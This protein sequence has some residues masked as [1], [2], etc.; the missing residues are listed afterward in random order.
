MIMVGEEGGVLGEILDRLASLLEHEAET[1]SRVKAAVRYPIIVIVAIVIAFTVLVTLVIPKFAAL[2]AQFKAQLPLPTRILIGINNVIKNYWYLILVSIFGAYYAFRVYISTKGGRKVW[3][4]VKIRV[5]IIG[6]LILKVIM[7][8]FSRIFATLY[9][10]GLPM[11]QSLEIV[12]NTL[13]NVIIAEVIDSVKEEVRGGRG[14][15]EPMRASGV[16]PSIVS[17]MVAI[18]EESGNL[19]AMLTKVSD[20]YDSEVEYAI[21]NLSTM[22][23]PVLLVVIGT[24]VLFLALGVFLPLWDMIS[25]IKR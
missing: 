19:D 18:G 20:Y 24:M 8:R 15:S 10:S 9:R 6:E 2:F 17:Q 22:I 11:L 13:N 1:R 25:V 23:E 14:L 12:S 16:F 7:S 21:R 5:P 3:D 4:R